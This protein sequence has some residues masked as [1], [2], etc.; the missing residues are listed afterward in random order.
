MWNGRVITAIAQTA[1]GVVCR[2]P[3]FQKLGKAAGNAIPTVA[4]MA[5]AAS[6]DLRIIA[7]LL[8]TRQTEPDALVAYAREISQVP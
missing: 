3:G 7:F 8:I 2:S 5:T 1:L 4:A 6:M